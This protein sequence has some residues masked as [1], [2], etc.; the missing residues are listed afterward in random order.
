MGF[1]ER[2][3]NK[4]LVV[5]HMYR[6]RAA[7]AQAAQEANAEGDIGKV[8]FYQ[9]VVVAV[10]ECAKTGRST[11]GWSEET[12]LGRG[13]ARGWGLLRITA[14]SVA[15]GVGVPPI[16]LPRFFEEDRLPEH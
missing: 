15:L 6:I 16:T 5:D 10:D 4:A 3:R 12:N 2:W 1:R 8:R 11:Y 13:Y 9:G 14:D 7:A